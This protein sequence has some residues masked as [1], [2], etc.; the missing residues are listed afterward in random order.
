M[1][2]RHFQIGAFQVGVR[3]TQLFW[4]FCL[5]DIQEARILPKMFYSILSLRTSLDY[6]QVAQKEL[7]RY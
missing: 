5:L 4:V 7:F 6:L 2:N 1:V 3:D